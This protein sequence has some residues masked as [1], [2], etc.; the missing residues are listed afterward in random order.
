MTE[1]L[2]AVARQD[3]PRDRFEVIVVDDGSLTPPEDVV[4]TFPDQMQITLLSQ[5]NQG[6]AAARN[7]GAKHAKG[8]YLA[9]LDDDCLPDKDWLRQFARSFIEK[10]DHLLGGQTVNLLQHN[11]YAATSQIIQD[12]VYAYYNAIPDQACFFAT[13]NMAIPKAQ[14]FLTG[15]FDSEFRT[16]EDREF[17]DRWLSCGYSMIYVPEAVMYHAHRLNLLNFWRQHFGYGCGAFLFHRI[18]A[19]RQQR[20]MTLAQ[21]SFYAHLLTYPFVNRPQAFPAILLAALVLISQMASTLGFL[22]ESLK[23]H[24][25]IA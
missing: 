18:R 25:S 17:C 11:P 24:P 8:V 14:F 16:S 19:K 13:S 22:W 5:T 10:P 6:P 3:Y 2:A 12:A 7:I 20:P 4:A 21:Q 23:K 9:F 1:C 15:G